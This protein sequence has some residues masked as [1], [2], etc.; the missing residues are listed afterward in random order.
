MKVVVVIYEGERIPG[1]AVKGAAAGEVIG[2]GEHNRWWQYNAPKWHCT[3]ATSKNQRECTNML[4]Q[5]CSCGTS[6]GRVSHLPW[7]PQFF[8]C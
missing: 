8:V 2:E 3:P 6:V 1:A 5:W 4:S 7:T